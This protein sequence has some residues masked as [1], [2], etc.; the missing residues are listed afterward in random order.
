[1]MLL[2]DL[3]IYFGIFR[4]IYMAIEDI[5]TL[6]ISLSNNQYMLGVISVCALFYGL[7][8]IVNGALG[9]LF[10][11]ILKKILKEKISVGDYRALNWIVPGFCV[12]NIIYGLGF[13]SIFLFS[14]LTIFMLIRLL[15]IEIIQGKGLPGIFVFLF[16]FVAESYII[17]FL[18]I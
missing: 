18:G 15:K 17:M 8:G 9:L 13:I 6:S 12:F 11:W 7:I 16:C 2:L 14:Y 10:V 3:F 5:R 1:M 4:L